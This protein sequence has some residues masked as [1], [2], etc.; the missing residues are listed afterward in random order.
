VMP[1]ELTTTALTM[2]LGWLAKLDEHPVTAKVADIGISGMG[3]ERLSPIGSRE[4]RCA[5]EF[6]RDLYMSLT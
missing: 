5:S 1:R 4:G 6:D 2:T 3:S